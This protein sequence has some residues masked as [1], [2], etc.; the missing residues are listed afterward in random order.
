MVI[1]ES[2]QQLT[3]DDKI[4]AKLFWDIGLKKNCA[5][6]LVFMLMNEELTSRDIEKFTSL[7]QP[8]VSLALTDLM[9]KGW[10]DVVRHL[11]EKKGRPVK[12]FQICKDPEEIFQ[13]IIQEVSDD[14]NRKMKEIERVKKIIKENKPY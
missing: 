14:Y 2:I 7:R 13:E 6:V 12:I 4:L 1:T 5:R 8:E 10:I 11:M 9:K 3:N